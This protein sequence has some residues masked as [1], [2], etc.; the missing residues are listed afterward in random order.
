MWGKTE[1]PAHARWE[2]DRLV[3]TVAG[4]VRE[5]RTERAWERLAQAGAGGPVEE[6]T[7]GRGTRRRA[8]RS[9]LRPDS[10]T[11]RASPIGAQRLVLARRLHRAGAELHLRLAW[12]SSSLGASSS[13]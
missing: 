4:A 6:S 3:L 5:R 13:A 9:A 7:G 11:V 12:A 8:S 10:I 2:R 1:A